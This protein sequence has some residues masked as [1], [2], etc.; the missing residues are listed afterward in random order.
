M[1]LF[2]NKKELER[3]KKENKF[4]KKRIRLMEC[5]SKEHERHFVKIISDGLR[6][7][8]SLAAKYMSDRRKQKRGKK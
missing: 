1:F 2:K 8:S 5:K 6:H 3:L 4:L 7:G